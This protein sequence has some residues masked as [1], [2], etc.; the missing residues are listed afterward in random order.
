MIAKDSS[1]L[2]ILSL[3]EALEMANTKGLDLVEVSPLAHP[4][5]CKIIS[6]GKLKYQQNKLQHK[7][8]VKKISLKGIRLS[9]N[10]GE[11]DIDVRKKQVHKFLDQ[12]HKVKIELRL[13][14]REKAFKHKAREVVEKFLNK[15]EKEF[16][17]EQ[18]IKIQGWQI[19]SLISKK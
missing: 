13:R 14:G 10:I 5:V 8:K 4:P 1:Q 12:G 18:E 2:G 19:T 7:N 6:F 17:I 9:L 3:E 15:L 16:K 11:H